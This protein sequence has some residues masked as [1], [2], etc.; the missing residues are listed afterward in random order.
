M[1]APA[2]VGLTER[3]ASA[4]LAREG[5][6]D[7]PE[8]PTHPVLRLLRKFWGLSAWMLELIAALSLVLHKSADVWVA[9]ALLIVNALLSFLQEQRASAA[10]AALRRRLQVSARVQRDGAWRLV[11]A[12]ELVLGDVVRLRAGDFVPADMR[13]VDGDLRVDESALT[14][15]SLEIP[16][17]VDDGL[18]SGSIVRRGEATTI[19]TATGPRTFVGRT[20]Q[21]VESAHPKLH[22]EEITARLVKWLFVIV[23]TL[24]GVAFALSIARGLPLLDILPLSLVLLMSAV[25]VALPVMFTVSTAVGTMEL[26][27]HGVLVT[28]LAAVEDA[29]NMDVLCADKTGTLTMNRLALTGVIAEPGFTEDDVVRTAALSSNAANQDQIDLAFLREASERHLLDSGVKTLSFVPFTPET[30]RT[31][32]VVNVAGRTTRALKGALR[33]IAELAGLPP[34]GLATLEARA[35]EEAAKGA[36][37]LAVGRG[38]ADGPVRFVGVA[39]MRDAPRPDS[40]RLIEQLRF[41]GVRVKMLTGDGLPVARQI[42]RELGLDD[43]MPAPDLRAAEKD[44]GL[45]AAALAE[46]SEGFA[47]VFPEDKFL[48][49]KSLQSSGH[50]V[51]MTG[52]GVNDA[53]ALSQAEVGIAVSGA[54][55]VAKGAAS[56]VLTEEGL[57]SIVDLIRIGRSIYQRVLTWIINKVSRTILKA[58][59]VVVAFLVTGRFVI[60]ALG[61]LLLTFTTDFVK[62]ALSADRVRPSPAPESWRIGPL[63]KVALVLGVLM[64]LEA[65]GLL[66]IGERIFAPPGDRLHTFSFLTLLFFALFSIVSI[67]ERRAFWRSRPGWVLVAALIAD[68]LTGSTIGFVGLAD[69]GP[70]PL[71]QILFIAGYAMVCS[72]LFNDAVKVVL[73]ER[74]WTA[75]RQL[76]SPGPQEQQAAGGATRR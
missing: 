67:R 72:L 29:A 66:A 16:R 21:L 18:Y 14:G 38:E 75:P 4:R 57:G 35:A 1:T 20:T 71:M 55:D 26:G 30:R 27:R 68:A 13:I 42:A 39:F 51:G 73:T 40:R 15:E 69:L 45:H 47:E 56:I 65:L 2:S 8:A 62:I 17:R 74:L 61:M 34:E 31:E 59:F 24:V 48:V 37:V 11:P 44:G 7:V 28:H 25:P 33:T 12:R 6:N 43:V 58:G 36:R 10:V 63:V 9:L 70:L 49:V 41:L 46:R 23:G 64:L 76:L 22:V 54:T 5:P 50:V 32:S 52:D 53:P 3:E 19:V 60:S